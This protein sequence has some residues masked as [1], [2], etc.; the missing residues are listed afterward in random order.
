MTGIGV[1]I[2][3]VITE[4]GPLVTIRRGPLGTVI[5]TEHISYDIN[6][7]SSKPFI[8]EHHLDGSFI[9]NTLIELGDILTIDLTGESFLVMNKTPDLF[10]GSIVEYSMVIYKCNSTINTR[11][12]RAIE[13]RDDNYEMVQGWS[14]VVN[15]A[16]S[17]IAGR[18]FG[19][20]INQETP[21]G[22]VEVDAINLFVPSTYGIKPLDR[23]VQ[24]DTKF[25]KVERVEAFQ[26]PG[27]DVA[28]L[29]EDTRT[30]HA[31]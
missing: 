8:R 21:I 15:P 11:L 30:L 17:I 18:D 1:D 25:Y 13:F 12:L 23:F 10:Q 2:A 4:L 19:T 31:I 14:D 27:I 22:Q 28:Y 16:Y 24:L 6:T 20:E 9:Y 29:T 7:Q 3:A 26:F 5:G